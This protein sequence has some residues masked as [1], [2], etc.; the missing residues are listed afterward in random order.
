MSFTASRKSV[1]VWGCSMVITKRRITDSLAMRQQAKNT[2]HSYNADDTNMGTMLFKAFARIH[3]FIL[4]E[5]NVFEYVCVCM[6]ACLTIYY[7]CV[8]M[9][10]CCLHAHSCTQTFDKHAMAACR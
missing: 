5:N 7:L 4:Q 9:K 2:S 10:L 6:H 8:H 1:I 3:P